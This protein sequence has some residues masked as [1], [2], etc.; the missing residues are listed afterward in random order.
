MSKRWAL[1][2]STTPGLRLDRVISCTAVAAAAMATAMTAA[3]A[4]AV[5]AATMTA[6]AGAIGRNQGHVCN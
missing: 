4:A 2:R 5:A 1:G 3:V 6:V